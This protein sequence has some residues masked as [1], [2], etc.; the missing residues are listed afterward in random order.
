[1]FHEISRTSDVR[2]STMDAGPNRD[3]NFPRW[4][5]ISSWLKLK[6]HIWIRS[7]IYYWWQFGPQAKKSLGKSYGYVHFLKAIIAA[8][9]ILYQ[10]NPVRTPVIVVSASKRAVSAALLQERDRVYWSATFCSLTSGPNKDDYGM[11]ETTSLPLLRIMYICCTMLVSCAIT[12]FTTFD[13]GLTITTCGSKREIGRMGSTALKLGFR[14]LLKRKD[15]TLSTLAASIAS[16]AKLNDVLIAIV[17]LKQ[18][19]QTTSTL[20]PTNE[21]DESLIAASLD[22]STRINE[23][24]EHQ[25]RSYGNYQNGRP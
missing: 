25:A 12:V 13:A 9:P 2:I 23:R 14:D 5:K 21:V 24:S 16:H 17:P 7:E 11:V 15:E 1:M 6:R 10:F 19:R 20:L 8:T 22:I 4:V 18:R 3:R